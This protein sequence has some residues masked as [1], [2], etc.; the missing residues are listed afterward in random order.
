MLS[1]QDLMEKLPMF[2]LM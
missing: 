2:H 1:S